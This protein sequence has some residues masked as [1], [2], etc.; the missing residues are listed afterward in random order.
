VTDKGDELIADVVLFATGIYHVTVF[1]WHLSV[2]FKHLF[3]LCN[4]L[5]HNTGTSWFFVSVE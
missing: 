5:W 1:F 4:K 3:T 2:L